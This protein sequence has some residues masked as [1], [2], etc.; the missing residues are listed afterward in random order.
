MVF[1]LFC[2]CVSIFYFSTC[3]QRKA[4]KKN[5]LGLFVAV[6]GRVPFVCSATR[7]MLQVKLPRRR[8][9]CPEGTSPATEALLFLFLIFVG[10]LRCRARSFMA[11][12][13]EQRFME[14]ST[15]NSSSGNRIMLQSFVV[16][17]VCL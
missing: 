16:D 11:C 9:S 13:S 12:R 7:Q 4:D 5:L 1:T 8:Q 10:L 3:L 17:F 6:G 2:V 15:P 14:Q